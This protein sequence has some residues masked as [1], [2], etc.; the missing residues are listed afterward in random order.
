MG[1]LFQRKGLAEG[2]TV[3]RWCRIAL[4]FGVFLVVAGL[5]Y[6]HLVGLPDFLK[7]PLLEKI[8]RHGFE[9]RFTRARLG[10]GPAI[11]IENASFNPTNRAS[12]PRLSAGRTELK[13]DWNA[14]VRGHVRPDSI[15]VLNGQVKVPV[16]QR[17]GEMLSLDGVHLMMRLS[18]N[19][20]AQLTDFG[21]S[22]RGIKIRIYGEVTNFASMGAWKLPGQWLA[23][24]RQAGPSQPAP[25]PDILEDFRFGHFSRLDIH[26]S[27]DGHDMNTLRAEAMFTAPVVE[28]P[29]G[30]VGGLE[31]RAAAAHLL[32][33]TNRPFM[34][35]RAV[36]DEITTRWGTGGNVS[37]TAVFFPDSAT[38]FNA[39]LKFD[40]NDL[41]GRW[42][43]P[44]GANWVRAR[45]LWWDGRAALSPVNFRPAALE[46]TLRVARAD[47]TWG[48]VGALSIALKADQ[49]DAPTP[50]DTNWGIWAGFSPFSGSFHFAAT[51]IQSPQL[52]FD[53]LAVDAAWNAPRLAIEKLD[54]RLYGGRLGGDAD[55]D[56]ASRQMR[57]QGAAD[58]DPHRISQVL[59][60]AAQRWISQFT[61]RTPPAVNAQIR[62]V[63]PPWI[64][65]P[66]GWRDDLRASVQIAG[67]FSVGAATFRKIEVTSASAQFFYTN[68]V[69]TLPRLL[70]TRPDGSIQIDYT[71]NDVT[72]EFRLIVDS[73]LDPAD[74]FPWLEAQQ[75]RI[76][77]GLHF[78]TPPEIRGEARGLWHALNMTSFTGTVLASNFT[79]RGESV[80]EVHAGVE[81]T[82]HVL[83]VAGL[84]LSQGTGRLDIPLVRADLESKRIFL[85]NAQSTLDPKALVTAMGTN[86]PEFLTLVHFEVP[87]T[88]RASGSFV[89]GD[90]LATDMRFEIEGSR[91]HWTN[92]GAD[93]ISGTARWVGRNVLL[94]NIEASLYNTGSL[95]GWLAFYSAR[96]R[97]PGFRCDFTARDVDLGLLA[98]GLTGKSS[99]LEGRLDG[100]MALDAPVTADRETWTGNGSVHV[101]DALLWDIKIF[102]ILSPML[103]AISPGAGDSRAR[104]ASAV[105]T[106]GEGKVSSD[107]LEIHSTAVRLLYRGSV[108]MNKTI[109]GRVEAD[110]LRD[111]PV[112]GPFFSLVLTPFS[113]LFEY[114][115]SGSL[116]QPVFKPVY[117]PEFVMFMLRPFHTLKSLL[118]EA[119]ADAQPKKSP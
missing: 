87:P 70:A 85:T 11:I 35:A 49:A 51:N 37:L 59:T 48:S 92:L 94:T 24:R 41:E 69:W 34:Q 76:L 61:W 74:A 4:W 9:A 46:G 64:N 107:D 118:P 99:K 45:R 114:Q 18:S 75:Q 43:S 2:R 97:G 71:G 26:F 62:L 72:H 27:A 55:V 30:S 84:G 28:T 65:R 116:Q 50:A 113:K 25:A 60:P 106:V 52:Q 32:D 1:W 56:V 112:F 105:F 5:A 110:L 101:H 89:P 119:P 40:G 14:L 58:F 95:S 86:A 82:N 53:T 111:M 109:N 21:A 19:D 20:F 31:V 13:L 66:E 63:L 33:F 83:R 39:L 117:V 36:A 88:V 67:D 81:Y 3:F 100:D 108:T 42:N 17:F 96:G 22:F 77:R 68:R 57:L 6:V 79:V 7:G 91:F 80:N 54:A 90:A 73:R 115:I 78:S 29:W 93:K 15:E 47:S 23:A 102:G 44:S 104:Q 8:R 38:P 103:N 10:W 16:S 12:G 98:R